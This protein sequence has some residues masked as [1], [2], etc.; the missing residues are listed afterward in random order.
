MIPSVFK[1]L[2]DPRRYPIRWVIGLSVIIAVLL[3]TLITIG[4]NSAGGFTGMLAALNPVAPTLAA[5]AA[6]ISVL[7]AALALVVTA[8]SNYQGWQRQK[9]Q[10][11]IEAWTSWSSTTR[12]ARLRILG[13]IG[14]KSITSEQ[15]QSILKREPFQSHAGPVT[16]KQSEQL[17]RDTVEVLNGLER[18]AV[19]IEDDAYDSKTV[20][21]MGATIVVR[22]H[23]TFAQYIKLRQ[24][25]SDDERKQQR[26]Y[27]ALGRLALEFRGHELDLERV[28]QSVR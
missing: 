3:I 22:L 10:A 25:M 26:A 1:L 19:G 23:G 20:R 18:L 15:A 8:Y 14:I 24:T 5:G 7:I 17:Y 6:I 28:N 27:I 2:M 13:L 9:R 16:A 12:E 11:T 21:N 4:I